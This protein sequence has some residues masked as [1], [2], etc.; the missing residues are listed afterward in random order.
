MSAREPNLSY[1]ERALLRVLTLI[2]AQA[3]LGPIDSPVG[4][5]WENLNG[6]R[7]AGD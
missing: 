7:R 4:V 2:R 3:L 1:G 5:E 6:Q